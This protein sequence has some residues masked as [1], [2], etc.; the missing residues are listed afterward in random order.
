M[1]ITVDGSKYVGQFIQ[2]TNVKDGIG[3]LIYPDGSIFEGIF[4][5]DL[6]I[7]GRYISI[8]GDIFEGKMVKL[9]KIDQN[10]KAE[11]G[12]SDDDTQFSFKSH[13]SSQ[14]K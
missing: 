7:K 9:R 6:P 4:K 13:E 14:T 2:G 3:Q 5:N 1:S 10:V 12:D 8:C 11:N